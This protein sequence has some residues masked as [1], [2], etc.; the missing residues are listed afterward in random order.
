[1]RATPPTSTT[2]GATPG[3][4]PPGGGRRGRRRCRRWATGGHR[5]VLDQHVHPVEGSERLAA[6]AAGA[7]ASAQTA[8]STTGWLAGRRPPPPALGRSYGAILRALHDWQPS[9]SVAA[10]RERRPPVDP[11]DARS[12]LGADV[13]PLPASRALRWSRRSAACPSPTGWASWPRPARP[14]RAGRG[15]SCTAMRR[16]ATCC[17][18]AARSSPCWTSS[19]PGWAGGPRAAAVPGRYGRDRPGVPAGPWL[20]EDYPRLFTH[21]HLVSHL[22]LY[23]LASALRVVLLHPP[24]SPEEAGRPDRSWPAGGCAAEGPER[25]RRRLD[26]RE[27]AG[28]RGVWP[29]PR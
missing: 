22:W 4:S 7:S 21:P 6:S 14:P 15:S 12:I 19:G 9:A 5:R 10:A 24:R 8:V 29:L 3:R 16:R 25:R 20:A 28:G 18:T 2:A 17:G 13:N 1:V 27:G 23:D 26:K 11:G